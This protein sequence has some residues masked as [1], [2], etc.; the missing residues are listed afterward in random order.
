MAAALII[1]DYQNDFVHP[2]GALYVE[3]AE[4][5]WERIVR[6]IPDYDY[7][8]AT[9]D[10]HPDGHSSFKPE[11]PWP[12]HCVADTWGSMIYDRLDQRRIRAVFHKGMNPQFDEY[13][14]ATMELCAALN[15]LGDRGMGVDV[16]GVALEYCVAA[17][18][19]GLEKED[20]DVCVLLDCTAAIDP[21]KVESVKAALKEQG[22]AYK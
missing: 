2:S 8:Y 12:R 15:A 4:F 7:V 10:W 20:F 9:A 11:G 3:G 14:G 19:A 6:V 13:C 18:A 5:V 16:C 1:V 21:G 17:T 22:V